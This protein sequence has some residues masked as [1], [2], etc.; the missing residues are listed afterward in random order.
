MGIVRVTEAALPL[1]RR[2][3]NPNVVTVSSSAGSFWAVERHGGPGDAAVAVP[4]LTDAA[5][6]DLWPGRHAVHARNVGP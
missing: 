5:M 3:S 6:R 2:S 1:L 4:A